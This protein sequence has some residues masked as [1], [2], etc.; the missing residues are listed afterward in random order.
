[1]TKRQTDNQTKRQT[2]TDP[3][4]STRHSGARAA[5]PGQ[6][7]KSGH[8]RDYARAA[9]DLRLAIARTA[10]RLRTEAGSGLTPT[11]LSA[12]ASIEREGPLTPS[13]LAEV[14]GV[15]RPTVTRISAGLLEK[16]LVVREADD[17]DRRSF[18]LSV[19]VAGREFLSEIRSVKSAWL[20]CMLNSLPEEEAEVLVRAA[21]ILDR[22]IRAES[23]AGERTTG[24]PVT[25]DR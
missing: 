15:R 23:D 4:A 18:T 21:G 12:L 5:Q 1:V 3:A 19:S 7:S 17:R 11:A 16:G 14:E 10:R 13:R 6:V 9:A 25:G 20:E 22:A 8:G 24:H 2:A